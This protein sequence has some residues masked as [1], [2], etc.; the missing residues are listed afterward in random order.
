MYEPTA[1]LLWRSTLTDGWSSTLAA[2]QRSGDINLRH[3][4][5]VWL[6][7]A[8][9]GA[10]AGTTPTLDVSLELRDGEQPP[11]WFAGVLAVSQ[12]TPTAT[13]GHVSGGLHNA[14]KPLVLPEFGRIA[15]V[16]GGAGA[17]FTKVSISLYGR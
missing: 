13:S 6:A 7:V 15:A 9:A 5:D 3:V 8:V 11:N 4:T 1:R 10:V 12:V 16:V 17:S 14:T 2:T